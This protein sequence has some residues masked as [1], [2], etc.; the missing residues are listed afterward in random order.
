MLECQWARLHSLHVAH[1]LHNLVGFAANGDDDRDAA[2]VR[3]QRQV[4]GDFVDHVWWNIERIQANDDGRDLVP[5]ATLPVQKDR[6]VPL[7]PFQI[8]WKRIVVKLPTLEIEN[9]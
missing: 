6:Q 4:G 7:T 9:G 3:D 8:E 5:D 1:S 2:R